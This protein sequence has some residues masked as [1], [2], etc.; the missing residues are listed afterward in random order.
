MILIEEKDNR[1]YIENSTIKNAGLGVFAKQKLK[2]GDFLEIIGVMVDVKSMADVC[3]QYANKYKFAA[4]F[5][6]KFTR[7]II[8]MGFAAIVNHT[9]DKKLQNVELKY[10]KH[11]IINSNAG[12]C[13]YSF[14]RDV[15]EGEEILGSYGSEYD[16]FL[17]EEN[18][19]QMFLD[20]EL[21]NFKKLKR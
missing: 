13:V 1:F 2:K 16:N 6:D 15:E 11:S 8:P 12:S 19:W 18:Y 17:Q 20:L 5:S 7:H 9:N 10:I 3:T 21:Y 14:I 4:D